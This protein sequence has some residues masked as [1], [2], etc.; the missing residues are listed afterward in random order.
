MENS[1][2]PVPSHPV[3]VIGSGI[4]GLWTALTMADHGHRVLLVTKQNLMDSNTRYAQGGIAAA[5][6]ADD[7]PELHY[8]DTLEAGAGLCDAEPVRVLT[9]EGPEQLKALISAGVRFDRTPEGELATTLEAAHSRRR[10][11]HALGDATGF[12]IERALVERVRANAAIE[13]LEHAF[14]LDLVVQE[15]RCQGAVIMT[16]DHSVR[17]LTARATVLAAGG[18]GQAWSH[19]TNP[20]TA[21]GDG[22]AL[23]YRAGAEISDMEF[24]QFHPTALML[25]GVETFLISEAVRGE[26]ALLRN[27]A[28]ETFME[29]Y[30]PAQELAPRDVVARA[31]ASEMTHDGRDFVWLDL[32]HLPTE[33]IETRFPTIVDFCRKHGLNPPTDMLPVAPAAHYFIGGARTDLWGRT[34]VPGL[35]AVGEV[36]STGVHGANRLAS[37]SLL[38]AV[39]FGRRVTLAIGADQGLSAPARASGTIVAMFP[40]FGEPDLDVAGLRQDLQDEMWKEAGLLR[41]AQGLEQA[42]LRITSWRLLIEEAALETCTRALWELRNLL[43]VGDLVCRAALWREESRGTH[44]R[45]DYPE[46]DDN[47][48][49]KHFTQSL[50]V[51]EESSTR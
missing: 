48:W 12:E 26:G 47:R 11:V 18:V 14:V 37:N 25:P 15:G 27:Q 19:T 34:T 9:S 20:A 50:R 17:Y 3:L 1:K 51:L 41:N 10:V 46:K 28:G 44:F 8:R 36:A 43:Q 32:R 21:T 31:I 42:L 24:M 49:L 33:L 5:I 7:S 2:H 40:P 38:E 23:A 16:D 29:R 4:S 22:I 39:V 45:T 30:H 6:A 35:Y 13:T